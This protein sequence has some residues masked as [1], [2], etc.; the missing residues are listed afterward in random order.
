MRS[1]ARNDEKPRPS[2]RRV[3]ALN[4]L[5]SSYYLQ[6]LQ[7]PP[8]L[9]QFAQYLQFEHARQV[10]LGL[11]VAPMI[12]SFGPDGRPTVADCAAPRTARLTRA[13]IAKS[14]FIPISFRIAFC[15]MC[16]PEGMFARRQTDSFIAVRAK[17]PGPA[18]AEP[19]REYGLADQPFAGG[20]WRILTSSAGAAACLTRVAGSPA[21]H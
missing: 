5:P 10:P 19:G 16:N 14:F 1:P 8:R 9:E 3:G 7:V 15:V 2:R 4:L 6:T 13:P 11:H 21:N 20:E 18:E 17:S 12:G